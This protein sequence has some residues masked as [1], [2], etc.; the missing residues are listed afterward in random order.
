MS[1]VESMNTTAKQSVDCIFM[2]LKYI[3]LFLQDIPV[4]TPSMQVRSENTERLFDLDSIEIKTFL[5]KAT[6]TSPQDYITA[7]ASVV[8]MYWALDIEY[9]K[10]LKRTLSFVAG[11]ICQLESFKATPL[12]QKCVNVL[13][14]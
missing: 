4:V 13:Y 9:P 2:M 3:C 7:M 6:M 11:Q 5:D 12:L 14:Q 10:E 8:A 1:C